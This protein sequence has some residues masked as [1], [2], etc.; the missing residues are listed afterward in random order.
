MQAT[1]GRGLR[2]VPSLGIFVPPPE[3]YLRENF[4]LRAELS[5]FS[6][7]RHVRQRIYRHA[8]RGVKSGRYG[9]Q[10]MIGSSE[11]PGPSAPALLRTSRII[12]DEAAPVLY[13]TNTFQFSYPVWALR[14]LKSISRRNV[15]YIH[16]IRMNI[17]A[18]VGQSTA[19]DWCKV[20]KKLGREAT[21]LRQLH[22]YLDQGDDR[23]PILHPGLGRCEHFVKGL[24]EI[25]SL[26]RLELKG[27]F[28]ATWPEY[29]RKTMGV[30]A[31]RS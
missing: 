14:W 4:D 1:P 16:D 28:S 3:K 7:P 20:F 9:S 26:E 22:V 15:A 12:H 24:S 8:L 19:D 6:L 18:G 27:F 29:L 11:Q 30:R 10:I 21:Q 17:A 23:I 31:V 5:I 25:K 13:G 2:R